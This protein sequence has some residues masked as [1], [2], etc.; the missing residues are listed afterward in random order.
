MRALAVC[1]FLTA[2]GAARGS[3]QMIC[4]ILQVRNT[5]TENIGTPYET[6]VVDS[7][8]LTC[9]DGSSLSADQAHSS[10][11]TQIITLTGHVNYTDGKKRVTSE[12]AQYFK[13]AGLLQAR[14]NV[15]VTDIETKSRVEAPALDYFRQNERNP[16]ARM[17][18]SGGRGRAVIQQRSRSDSIG[19]IRR[20]STVVDADVIEI[21]GERAFRGI[22]NAVIKREDI[23]GYGNDLRYDQTGGQMQLAQEARVESEKYQLYGDTI[24]ALLTEGEDLREVRS[25]RNARLTA[26]D[27]RVTSPFLTIELDSG[28][29]NRLVATRP[30]DAAGKPDGMPEVLSTSFNLRADSIDARA[31][32]QKLERV[33]A[34]GHAFGER[35]DT[36]AGPPQ[37]GELP[38]Y[39]T[40]DWVTGD[41]IVATFTVDT[42]AA[43]RAAARRAAAPTL[44]RAD[45]SS[46]A[47]STDVSAANDGR[48]LESLVVS[49]VPG[50]PAS[51]TLRMKIEDRDSAAA[52]PAVADASPAKPP[53]WEFHHTLADR[54]IVEFEKGEVAHLDLKGNV[55]GLYLTPASR[56][57]AG[58][59]RPGGS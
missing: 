40:H 19:A 20:D 5:Y 44:E 38:Q 12:S 47:A 35:I 56:T 37:A 33:D 46:S 58:T 27:I 31:P 21:A 36:A 52:V 26:E 4:T 28:A 8:Q 9:P 30:A 57:A 59:N 7:V 55:N 54:I 2:L 22:G 53:E 25:I 18:T 43:A 45:R 41:T 49:G 23:R 39:L 51:A 11:A 1:L 50:A 48:V 3:A 29:V 15:V 14:G 24:R 6:T 32:G 10:V 17:V 13:N 16:E 34:V 42:A